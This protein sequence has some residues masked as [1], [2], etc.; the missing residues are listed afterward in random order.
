[1][2]ITAAPSRERGNPRGAL[3][4]VASLFTVALVI[5]LLPRD[6]EPVRVGTL[7]AHP[8]AVMI[9]LA[10]PATAVQPAI[11]AMLPPATPAPIATVPLADAA[12]VVEMQS[13]DVTSIFAFS[14]P[15]A[16][17]PVLP[18]T[19]L[20]AAGTPDAMMSPPAIEADGDDVFSTAFKQTGA[21]VRLA[22]RKTGEGVKTAFTSI[23]W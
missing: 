6:R 18:A 10:A 11:P 3:A 20:L 15:V 7:Q 22:L 13:P 16:D 1:M 23:P 14:T 9:A 2:R 19:P 8:H 4:I 21:A 5:A 17:P 12:P